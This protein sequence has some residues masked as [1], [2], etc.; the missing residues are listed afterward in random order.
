MSPPRKLLYTIKSFQHKDLRKFYET[1]SLAGVQ[2][3]HANRLRMQLA[4]LDTA[5]TME[6]MDIL[7][8]R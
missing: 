8:F 4:A 6:D 3:I 2:A 7:G 5:Q 1:G